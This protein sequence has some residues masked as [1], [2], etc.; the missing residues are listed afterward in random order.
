M[1]NKPWP[2]YATPVSNHSRGQTNDALLRKNDCA[3]GRQSGPLRGVA[4]GL[5]EDTLL[6]RWTRLQFALSPASYERHRHF[7]RS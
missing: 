3:W 4:G 7:T 2:H 1:P 6:Q 5:G